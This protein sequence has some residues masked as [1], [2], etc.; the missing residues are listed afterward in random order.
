M[1]SI[2][3]TLSMVLVF[4]LIFTSF[5]FVPKTAGAEEEEIYGVDYVRNNIQFFAPYEQYFVEDDLI[6]LEKE[7]LNDDFGIGLE[8]GENA[9]FTALRG[10]AKAI[11]NHIL[12][13]VMNLDRYEEGIPTEEQKKQANAMMP[14]YLQVVETSYGLSIAGISTNGEEFNTGVFKEGGA[15]NGDITDWDNAD[16]YWCLLVGKEYSGEYV[17]PGKGFD[18][19]VFGEDPEITD[20]YTENIRLVW[21][22]KDAKMGEISYPQNKYGLEFEKEPT[23]YV[24][25]SYDTYDKANS[26]APVE[27]ATIEL[28]NLDTKKV[29][30]TTTTD[31]NG[32]FTIPGQKNTGDSYLIRAYLEKTTADGKTY[33]DLSYTSQAFYPRLLPKKAKSVKAKVKGKKSAKKKDIKVTWKNGYKYADATTV[34]T[35][36][37]SKKKSKGYKKAGKGDGNNTSC[38]VKKMKKGTYY[39]KLKTTQYY[40]PDNTSEG[41]DAVDSVTRSSGY[42][43]PIKVKVK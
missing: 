19:F 20:P 28:Y 5:A 39:I 4:A 7:D 26:I 25:K 9:K 18:N 16:G 2:K 24:L 15:A 41:G 12:Y 30:C 36:Y 14:N 6:D 3:K 29:V 37:I 1:K 35:V 11:R 38:T 32:K 22:G 13:E 8:V 40:T 10:I 31:A 21:L 43:T 23:D 33:S 42:T 17:D 27:N 34:Y